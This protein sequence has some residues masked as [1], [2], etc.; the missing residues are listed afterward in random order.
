[1]T[2][3]ALLL[4]GSLALLAGCTNLA[5]VAPPISPAMVGGSGG[6]SVE[7]L[8]RG[9]GIFTRQCTACHSAEPVRK[10]TFEQWRHFVGEMRERTKLDDSEEAALLAYLRAASALPPATPGT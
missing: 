9:R 1:M 3:R 7:K 6:A 2:V 4:L 10:H 5:D 8:E